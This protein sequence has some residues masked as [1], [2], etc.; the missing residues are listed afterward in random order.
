[1]S[2]NEEVVPEKENEL[3]EP[4]LQ[5]EDIH[6]NESIEIQDLLFLTDF[7]GIPDLSRMVGEADVSQNEIE[8]HMLA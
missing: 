5:K 6:M 7:Y 1:V 2:N 8:F 4:S 3:L